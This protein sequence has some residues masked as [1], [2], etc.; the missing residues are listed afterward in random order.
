MQLILVIIHYFKG[1]PPQKAKTFATFFGE[2]FLDRPV[3]SPRPKAA[4]RVSRPLGGGRSPFG[5]EAKHPPKPPIFGIENASF[6]GVCVWQRFF[7]S[8]KMIPV[9]FF[10][11]SLLKVGR[12]I[13]KNQENRH[14]TTQRFC[15]ETFFFYLKL[16]RIGSEK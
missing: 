1:N 4:P 6:P 10:W 16:P 15:L 11:K 13:L 2:N 8:W 14:T 3:G 5:K 12:S 9:V 7:N